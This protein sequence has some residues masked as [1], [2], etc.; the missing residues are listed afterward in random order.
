M[1]DDD[2]DAARRMAA[3]AAAINIKP[4]IVGAGAGARVLCGPCDI[5]V[6]RGGDGRYYVVDA[7]RLMPPEP[8]AGSLSAFLIHAAVPAAQASARAAQHMTTVDLSREGAEAEIALVLASAAALG[9]D[10]AANTAAAGA[11]AGGAAGTGG[12]SVLRISIPG[13]ALY[14]RADAN[15]L[16]A[17]AGAAATTPAAAVDAASL[18]AIFGRNTIAEAFLWSVELAGNATDSQRQPRLPVF[19]DALLVA[20]ERGQHLFSCLRPEFVREWPVPLSSDA[21][22]RFGAHSAA[23]HNAEVRAAARSLQLARL[24]ALAGRLC[25]TQLI[26][27]NPRALVDEARL[28]LGGRGG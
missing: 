10:A 11:R 19:G 15:P 27:L 2:A 14:V 9:E 22:T 13:A 18:A 26:L 5:E 7:A 4:H 1:H 28:T 23:E 6:H 8:P 16:R 3:A 20:G 25:N 21:F 12:T 17:A 24:P